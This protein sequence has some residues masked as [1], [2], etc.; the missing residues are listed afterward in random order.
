M[1]LVLSDVNEM[2][3]QWFSGCNTFFTVHLEDMKKVLLSVSAVDCLCIFSTLSV[4][5]VVLKAL[6]LI[7]FLADTIP[8]PPFSPISILY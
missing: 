4:A 2:I 5:L 7:Y 1:G 8:F 3:F 6:F